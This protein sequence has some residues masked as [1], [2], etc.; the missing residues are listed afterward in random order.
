[1]ESKGIDMGSV[2][3]LTAAEEVAAN[4]K[5]AGRCEAVAKAAQDA[6]DWMAGTGAQMSDVRPVL[7]RDFRR[8]ALH[9]RK[10]AEAARRPMCVSVFGPSQQGKSYLVGSL[11]RRGAESTKIIFGTESRDF[12]RDLNPA[13]NKESTGL[14]TR[15]TVRPLTGLPGMP[16][17]FRMLSQTDVIKIMANAFMADFDPDSVTALDASV[18]DATLSRLRARAGRDPVGNLSEDEVYE[19]HE[20]F[21]R[22]F[23]NHICHTSLKAVWS[24]M[25]SLAPR[26]S[27]RDRVEL[28]SLL[29]QLTPTMTRVASGTY[30]DAVML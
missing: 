16:V 12:V 15:F 10:L 6:I 25:E 20:Y 11:A 21:D 26:L 3:E 1:M 22:Y 4:E 23:K 17:V 2:V 19:L 30:V 13:G 8:E 28:F 9:A 5:L 7:A 29:W 14:V 24:E 27:V 18:I